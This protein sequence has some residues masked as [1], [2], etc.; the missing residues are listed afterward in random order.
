MTRE[1]KTKPTGRPPKLSHEEKREKHRKYEAKYR[2]SGR[3]KINL[4]RYYHKYKNEDWFKEKR[5]MYKNNSLQKEA[6]MCPEEIEFRREK[7]R[8]KD[9]DYRKKDP[10][11][12]MLYDASKRS[13]QKGIE[14][15]LVVEDIIIPCVCPVLGI[16]L[17]RGDG[18]RTDNSPSL[19]RIDNTKGYVKGNISVISNRANALKNNGSISEFEKIINYMKLHGVAR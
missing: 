8:K 15:C 14:F 16:P 4:K 2:A 19:D 11:K 6:Q 17:I 5:I 3:A 13:K 12:S 9:R 7:K 18:K 10:R 1:F